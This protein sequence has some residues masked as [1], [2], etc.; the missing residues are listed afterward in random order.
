VAAEKKRRGKLGV[1]AGGGDLPGLL[2]EACKAMEREV[3]VVAFK[4]FAQEEHLTDTDHA[5]TDLAAVGKTLDHLH[6][7]ACEQVVLAGSV[8][9]PSIASLWP[10]LRGARLLPRVIK[11]GGDDAALK[12]IIAELESEGFEVVGA[13]DILGDLL[14]PSGTIGSR[15]PSR[16][17][18]LDIERGIEAAMALGRADVGQA[19][20]VQ[21]GV[22]LGVEAAEG[23]DALVARC[24]TLRLEG[25]GGVLVKLKKPGQ[26]RRADLPTIG[27][28]TVKAVAK[29]GLAGLAV[30]AGGTLVLGMDQVAVQADDLGVFAYGIPS[31]R[32]T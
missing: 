30:E 24:G 12:V 11:A 17:Q 26:E 21:Q 29:A 7:A 20:V 32:L 16:D 27:V 18:T 5:W 31:H 9:R 22:V 2:V 14:A 6:K 28:A 19:V 1:L 10:D 4:G 23:T 15:L 25:A 13:D 3:F 8:G